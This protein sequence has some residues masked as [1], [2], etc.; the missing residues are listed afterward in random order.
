MMNIGSN[1]LSWLAIMLMTLMAVLLGQTGSSHWFI[2][3][4]LTLT[5]LK[6]Q[7][8]VNF[9]MGLRKAPVFWQAIISA[10]IWLLTG[11]IGLV[12]IL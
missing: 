12:Y 9:F 2:I 1:T 3:F 7:L 5:S 6:A 11:T 8:V 4:A 10:Y